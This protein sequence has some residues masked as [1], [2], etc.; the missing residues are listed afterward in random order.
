M[1]RIKVGIDVSPLMV[2]RAGVG[3]YTANLIA[4]LQ[5]RNDVELAYFNGLEWLNDFPA[6]P[7][8]HP[9]RALLVR[10]ISRGLGTLGKGGVLL[11]QLFN[12]VYVKRRFQSEIHRLRLQL[13]HGTNYCVFKC[14]VPSILTIYDISCF[15]YPETHP[16]SR[17]AWQRT[18]IPRSIKVADHIVT[19]SEFSRK[20]IQ[21][22]FG[23]PNDR[24]SVVQGGVGDVFRPQPYQ[25]IRPPLAGYSLEPGR[26]ILTVGTVEPRKNLAMLV[27]AFSALPQSLQEQYPLVIVGMRGWKSETFYA[28]AARGV[29]AGAL[30][31]LGYIAAGDLPVLY[32]GA[33]AFAYPSIYEGFGL[34]PLEAMAS[35]VPVAVSDCSALPEVVG[36]AALRLDPHD[37]DAWAAALQRLLEDAALRSRLADAGL[38]RAAQLSW[39]R[40][41]AKTA[42]LYR[43][44]GH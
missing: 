24:I 2:T 29:A 30:R 38:S 5:T 32:A 17:V 9:R 23:V 22:Y 34:P 4:Q 21:D 43:R 15:R 6:M 3:N 40:S 44:L 14:V 33:A 36:D 20:E 26:Y 19:I 27:R 10:M 12:D 25:T 31:L 7:A 13:V 35:G 8:E 37:V 11:K 41:A 42:D 28:E 16:P 1:S 39:E 18:I